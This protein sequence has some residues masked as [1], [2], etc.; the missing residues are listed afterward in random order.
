MLPPLLKAT[1]AATL[2]HPRAYLLTEH[3]QPFASSAAFSNRFRAWCDDAGLNHLSS[4]GI[5]KA[6]GELM[7]MHGATQYQ[8]MAVHG[9]SSAKTSEVYTRGA[10]RAN[11][12]AQGITLLAA[13]D[14]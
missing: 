14:W 7:A 4:H 2:Q 13:M 3:G 1:R 11:L 10:S 8:I 9:H 12:G 5:R 6:A